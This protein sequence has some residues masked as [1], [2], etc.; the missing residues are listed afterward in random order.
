VYNPVR[1]DII[2]GFVG[3]GVIVMAVDNLPC[4]LPGESSTAFSEALVGFIP[5]IVKADYTVGF[6]RLNLPDE[7]KK[8][9]IL[10]QGRLTP[11]YQY[12]NKFL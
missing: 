12:I 11:N 6:D 3:E 8:A 1:R 5:D 10:H 4:E 9:V 2:E 7:I